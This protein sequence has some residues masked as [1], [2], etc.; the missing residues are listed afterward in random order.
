[1]KVHP[2][3][4]FYILRPEIT[5]QQQSKNFRKTQQTTYWKPKKYWMPKYKQNGDSVFA[6][7]LPGGRFALLCHR[8]SHHCCRPVLYSLYKKRITGVQSYKIV[9]VTRACNIQCILHQS[10]PMKTRNFAP[11]RNPVT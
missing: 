6:F 11:M 7:S 8:Q 10:C 1:M 4:D 3:V 2:D 9:F 5:G